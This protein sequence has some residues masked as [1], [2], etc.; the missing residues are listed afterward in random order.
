M[1]HLKNLTTEPTTNSKGMGNIR[2]LPSSQH[3]PHT[4]LLRRRNLLREDNVPFHN[5]I[6]L[7]P[8]IRRFSYWH[9]LPR[10]GRRLTGL[11]HAVGYPHA[12]LLTVNALNR[13]RRRLRASQG[14]HKQDGDLGTEIVPVP[15]EFRVWFF[16]DDEDEVLGVTRGLFV[17]CSRESNFRA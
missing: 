9:A 4:L 5:Q 16:L 10:H 15:S 13:L 8:P 1:L 11:D 3:L 6:T 12:H 14:I 2:H 7:L 17:P